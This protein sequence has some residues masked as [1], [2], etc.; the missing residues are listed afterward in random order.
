M[1][2]LSQH[3]DGLSEQQGVILKT[4]EDIA[5]KIKAG[6]G[7]LV[8]LKS[9]LGDLSQQMATIADERK[10]AAREAEYAQAL[11]DIN[12]LKA[13]VRAPSKARAIGAGIEPGDLAAS[14]GFFY[15]LWAS[16]SRRVS[17]DLNAWGKAQLEGMGSVWADVPPESKATLGDTPAAG[18]NI[19]PSAVLQS[20]IE[21]AVPLNPYR[22]LLTVT[23]VGFVTGVEIPTE[24]LAPTR[25]TIVGTGELKPKRDLLTDKYTATMYTL[26]EIY[27]VG[28][29]LLRNSRGVAEKNIRS[30]LG[31]AFG[32]GESYYVLRGSGTNEPKG[33]LT[34]IG[35]T[36]E[37]HTTFTPSAST[38]AGS[39]ASAVAAAAG[40]IANRA[41]NPDGVVVNAADFWTMVAQGTDEAGFFIA[42]SGGPTSVDA[43]G[44]DM[45][46]WGLRTLGDPNMPADNLVVGAY[47]VAELFTGD[48][49]RVD[50]SEEAGERWDRNL[51][52]FRGEEEIG[53]NADPYV[54]T[55]HFQRISN[56]IA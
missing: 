41:V 44:L 11:K 20:F 6:D 56:L 30:R 47:K 26:A 33:I 46:I 22:T 36:G 9:Q 38:L 25:A 29:Q 17:P 37:F 53:F 12:E 32:L 8:E 16:K 50:V 45:R 51:T 48:Q 3:I 19:V 21:I 5:E 7:D 43:T 23:P 52:G 1:P 14:A 31:R 42:P 10:A 13:G 49:Y 39:A 27:D 24:G 15:S 40:P 2:D 34:S 35:T 18:G 54:T 28:N 4:M 55:G